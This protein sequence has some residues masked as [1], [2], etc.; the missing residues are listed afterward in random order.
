ML[1]RRWL[2]A[3][4]AASIL[5]ASSF[6]VSCS[7]SDEPPAQP[8]PPIP[9]TDAAADGAGGAASDAAPE[10]GSDAP[11]EAAPEASPEAEPDVAPDAAPGDAPDGA[12]G[13]GAD[14][15]STDAPG[16]GAP[17]PKCPIEKD[18]TQVTLPCDCYGTIV[19]DPKAQMPSC[20][21]KV[22]CCPSIKGLKCE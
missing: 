4:A 2:E 11:A 1:T 20:T 13:D 19:T 22:V 6:G 17:V 9:G 15:G 12:P 3:A 21:L 7:S 14:T 8:A 16:D 18:L 5:F 10:T